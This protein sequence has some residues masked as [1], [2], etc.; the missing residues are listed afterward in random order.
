MT[1]AL[2]PAAMLRCALTLLIAFTAGSPALAEVRAVVVGVGDYLYLDADLQGPPY[3]AA[4]MAEV[5]VARGVDPAA[6]QVLGAAAVPPG[7]VTGA[8]TRAGILAALASVATAARPGDTV[9]FYFSGHGAQAPD[10][11]GDEAGGMDEILLPADAKGWSG[12]AQAVENALVDDTLHDWAAGLL[13][14]Q[15]AVVGVI[16][17]CHSATGFRAIGGAGVPRSLSAAGLGMPE[18]G[19]DAGKPE[20]TIEPGAVGQRLAGD[21]VFLYASQSD[22]R[23]FEYPVGDSGVWHGA[24]TLGLTNVLRTATGASWAQVLAATSDT[25]VQGPARQVPEGEGPLL[26][27]VVFGLGQ[28]AL[29]HRL[30]DGRVAAGL[31]AGLTEGSEM[32]LYAAAAG[33]DPLGRAVLTDVAL[34]RS[35]L[36]G[37]V[38]AG[39]RW[40]EV[41]TP[42]PPPALRVAAPVQADEG[43]YGRWRPALAAGVAGAADLVPVLVGGT[44]A[45]TGADGVLDP[46]GPGSSPRVAVQDGETEAEALARVLDRAAHAL[47]LTRMFAAAAA[48]RALIGGP[49][50][51]ASY[52]R[53]PGCGVAGALAPA[54]PGDGLAP[55]DRVWITV[56]NRGTRPVDLSILYF[57]ADFSIAPIWPQQ[58]LANRLAPGESARGGLQIA[59]D[60]GYALEELMILGVAVDPDAARVDLTRLSEPAMSRSLAG[61]SGDDLQWFDRQMQPEPE[62][63]RGFLTR[64]ELVLLRQTVRLRPALPPELLQHD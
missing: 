48:G 1:V 31:L 2:Y 14:R 7:V 10:T 16:D 41:E 39:A 11:S 43:D 6:M 5:L 51:E 49:P 13:A 33:G 38:P 42:A 58:G 36:A 17:A 63:A 30:A 44:L 40:A 37:P 56:T 50:L 19:A 53:R 9:V 46:A 18:A 12:A 3:D 15:V 55:C 57:N 45:L 26:D 62:R 34:R 35:G 32:A 59:P 60:S 21:F 8:P 29:R 23:S 52:A 64:P 54:D 20:A 22:Q 28:S 27:R 4:L 61:V 47:R 25:M 24:F